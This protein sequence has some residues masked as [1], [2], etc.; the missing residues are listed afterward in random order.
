M[1]QNETL[2][3]SI[4][5]PLFNGFKEEGTKC[6]LIGSA[7]LYPLVVSRLLSFGYQLQDGDNDKINYSCRLV[8]E[9]IHNFCNIYGPLPKR[10]TFYTV[11]KICGDFLKSKLMTGNLSFN[12]IDFNAPAVKSLSEG[13]ASASFAVDSTTTPAQR[14][15]SFIDLL[16]APDK[17]I[18]YR[19]RRLEW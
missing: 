10:L 18:L 2:T 16:A 14:L 1:S 4:T 6:Q 15:Q 13:D 7:T 19:F 8:S 11:D 3:N 5:H 12:D 17:N 9:Y